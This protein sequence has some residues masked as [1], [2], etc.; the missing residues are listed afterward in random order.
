MFKFVGIPLLTV[1]SNRDPSGLL[2]KEGKLI[3]L[4]IE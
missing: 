1:F 3:F 4:S 2:F